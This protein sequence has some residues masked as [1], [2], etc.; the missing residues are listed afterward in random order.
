MSLPPPRELARRCHRRTAAT[1][2]GASPP[3]PPRAPPS[4]GSRGTELLPSRRGGH[5]SRPRAPG[6][7]CASAPG[8]VA[9]ARDASRARGR[10]RRGRGRVRARVLRTR[11]SAPE[12]RPSS[13][14]HPLATPPRAGLPG[15][16]T[17]RPRATT[18]AWPRGRR[19]TAA[20]PTKR[21]RGR[22][23]PSA[24]GPALPPCSAGSFHTRASP[25]RSPGTGTAAASPRGPRRAHASSRRG[26]PRRGVRRRRGIP[27][28]PSAAADLGTPRTRPGA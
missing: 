5:P 26:G 2:R 12:R 20:P 19:T 17:R 15:A 8:R 25:G 21:S 13:W 11:R 1:R 18:V 10:G 4:A 24:T 22:T 7:P 28:S 3:S 16:G 9:S 23:P 6:P 14:C 27:A